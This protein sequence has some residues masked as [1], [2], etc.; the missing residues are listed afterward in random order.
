MWRLGFWAFAS[1]NPRRHRL[2]RTAR[3]K[4]EIALAEIDRLISVGVR[5]R[6]VLA[7]PVTVSVRLSVKG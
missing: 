2:D 5:F 3:T 6:C 1:L 7:D 4:P